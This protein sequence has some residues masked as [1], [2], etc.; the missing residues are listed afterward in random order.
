[1]MPFA[2][3]FA[4]FQESMLKPVGHMTTHGSAEARSGFN[5]RSPLFIS[6]DLARAVEAPNLDG[7]KR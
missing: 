2:P 4:E 7:E 1:M 3:S 5:P 6:C